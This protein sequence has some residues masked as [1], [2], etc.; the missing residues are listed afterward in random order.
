[1]VPT[2]SKDSKAKQ[3]IGIWKQKRQTIKIKKKQ[4]KRKEKRKEEKK[5]KK[6]NGKKI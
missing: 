2:K 5:L 3:F 6:K 1:M 4:N